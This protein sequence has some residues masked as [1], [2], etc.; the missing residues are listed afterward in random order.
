MRE[1]LAKNLNTPIQ[2]VKGIG[3]KRAAVFIKRGINTIKDL[4]YY[5]PYDYIDL[6]E[7]SKIS[8]LKKITSPEQAIS[9]VGTVRS[10]DLVGRPPKRYCIIILGDETGIVPLV[11]FQNLQYF[12]NAYKIG[13]TLAVS[14]KV[15]YFMNKFQLAHP[16]I[17]RIELNEKNDVKGLLQIRGLIPKYSMWEDFKSVNINDTTLRKILFNVVNEYADFVEEVLSTQIL[18]EYKLMSLKEAIKKVHFPANAEEKYSS[19]RRLK[20]DEWFFFQLMLALRRRHTKIEL[21]GISFNI[22]SRLARQLVDSLPFKLTK[23]QIKVI[24]EITEDMK[25]PRPMNR[26]IQGDVGSGKTI[27]ALI[28]M[29]IAVDNGY[30]VAFMAPTEILAEQ[31]FKSINEFLKKINVDVK[32]LLGS[33]KKSIKNRILEEIK[34]GKTNIIVG[35][36]ALIQETVE[37]SNLG[38]VV[39]DEQHR[40]GVEQRAELMRK[41]KYS[42]NLNPDVL[43]MTATPIPRTLSLTL[44]GDLDVSVIDEIPKNRKPIETKVIGES[45]TDELY[46]QIRSIISRGQQVYVIYPLI[47]ESEKLDLK[48]AVESYEKFKHEIFRDLN[49]GLVHGRM[50]AEERDSVMREFKDNKINILVATTVIEVG[51]DIPNATMM[52]IEHAERFGLSQLHQLRGRVGRGSEQSFCVLV[53]PDWLPALLNRKKQNEIFYDAY[54]LNDFNELDKH[55]A[56]VRIQTM[57]STNDGFKISEVDLR[58]RGPGD[59]FGTRQSGLPDFNIANVLEDVQIINESRSAAFKLVETDSQLR[60]EENKNIRKYFLSQLKDKFKFIQV[61]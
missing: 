53:V 36:H 19:R 21:P 13:E 1:F 40:F 32:L 9:V 38:L 34:T 27:V 26:L 18:N 43:V 5:F 20:F 51:I 35:T 59:F 39:I 12:K 48:T 58:L 11:F 55:K 45:N 30:Q 56:L 42:L 2:Y 44:Y 17:D 25:L 50:S 49:V 47:E 41:G 57:L 37:F 8:D 60:M 61:G 4:L 31:H 16:H 54:K 14:G 24:K 28:A 10:I 6:K 15:S 3:P 29:L 7:V 33:Q 23:A 52:V 22:K 46:Q